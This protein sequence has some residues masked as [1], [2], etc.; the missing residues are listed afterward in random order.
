[1]EFT[2]TLFNIKLGKIFCK[3]YEKFIYIFPNFEKIIPTNIPGRTHTHTRNTHTHTK[4]STHIHTPHS[5]YT[6]ASHTWHKMVSTIEDAVEKTSNILVWLICGNLRKY[7][8]K[9]I[10]K[11][12]S[13]LRNEFAKLRS[14][15]EDQSKRILIWKWKLR[16]R[17]PYSK[18]FFL[19][20]G[21]ATAYGI[22]GRHLSVGEWT[23][24]TGTGRW[25]LLLTGQ[26]WVTLILWKTDCQIMC[27][28][29]IKCTHCLI[30]L[31]V[32]KLHDTPRHY[33]S[34]NWIRLNLM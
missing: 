4:H 15:I 11:A 18:Q 25:L 20:E 32:T 3:N 33:L 1:M 21:I 6:H 30:N 29:I 8:Q 14:E 17:I 13:S 2:C 31:K 19:G 28:M 7:L 5:L 24:R 26:G 22:R 23:L 34:Q 16:K 27:R 9:N 10:L 12:V